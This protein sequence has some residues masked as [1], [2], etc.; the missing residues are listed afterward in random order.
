MVVLVDAPKAIEIA[1]KFLEKHH[2]TVTLKSSTLDEAQKVWLITL[3]VGFLS[4]NIKTVKVNANDGTI[5]G[6]E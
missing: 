3:D 6:Y 5:L 2:D 1:E 4:E